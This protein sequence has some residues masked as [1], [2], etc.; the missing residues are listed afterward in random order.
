M[1]SPDPP[2]LA[3]HSRGNSRHKSTLCPH[4]LAFSWGNLIIFSKRRKGKRAH[5][6]DTLHS[7]LAAQEPDFW[8][9]FQVV[10]PATTMLTWGEG[11]LCLP[12]GI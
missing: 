10:T 3:I 7:I 5:C 9:D 1:M 11:R 6:G 4:G 8:E 2:G 12:F